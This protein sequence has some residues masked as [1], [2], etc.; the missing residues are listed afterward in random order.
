MRGS[1]FRDVFNLLFSLAWGAISCE[2]GLI[3]LNLHHYLKEC[4]ETEHKES[5]NERQHRL[6]QSDSLLKIV[7]TRNLFNQISGDLCKS[8]SNLIDETQNWPCTLDHKTA[9]TSY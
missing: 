2:L 8:K 5:N 9:N 7:F 4:R 1:E 3:A 6:F